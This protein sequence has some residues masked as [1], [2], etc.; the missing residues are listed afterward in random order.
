M[1]G[2]AAADRLATFEF[3]FSR[4]WLSTFDGR[5]NPPALLRDATLFGLHWLVCD[6]I[7]YEIINHALVAPA[8][9]G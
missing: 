7:N 9:T 1:I 4:R 5:F 2:R 8:T 3:N 6:W